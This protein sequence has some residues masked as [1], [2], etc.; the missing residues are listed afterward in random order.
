[1]SNTPNQSFAIQELKDVT[2]VTLNERKIV[3]A[4]VL[5]RLDELVASLTANP[6]RK[7]LLLDFACVEYISSPALGKLI[8]L[9]KTLMTGGGRLALCNIAPAIKEAFEIT[10]LNQFFRIEPHP[11]EDDPD[12]ELG[13][14]KAGLKPPGPSG[15]G[16]ASLQPP[17]PDAE[18]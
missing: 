3:D 17:R 12:G 16:R 1:M 7:K 14:V 10:K 8:T 6:V 9:Q 4:T 5:Q 2:V 13:G 11:E 15:S 18:E